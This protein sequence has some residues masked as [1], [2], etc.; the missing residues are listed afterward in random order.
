MLTSDDARRAAREA[1]HAAREAANSKTLEIAARA[2]FAASGLVHLMLGTLA[3]S[4]ANHD[5]GEPD[6]T[7]ALAQVAKLPGGMV[8]LWLTVAGFAALGLWLLLQ[9]LFGVGSRS[10]K[11]WARSLVSAGKAL[12]YFTLGWTALTIAL[13]GSTSAT[14]STRNTSATILSFPGGQLLLILVGLIAAAIGMY[15]IHKGATKGFRDDIFVP[16]GAWRR[17]IF[18]LAITGYLAKGV[19]IVVVGILFIVAAVQVDPNSASGLDGALRALAGLPQG[20][21]ILSGV[22]AGLIAYGVYSFARARLAR[23]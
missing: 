13:G 1:K 7:G 11:R 12:A 4:V 23:F 17:S 15:F 22:G 6:Q 10:K 5:G 16:D 2:G 21:A 3:I 9:A 18:A 20:E 19:A 8:A 14:R